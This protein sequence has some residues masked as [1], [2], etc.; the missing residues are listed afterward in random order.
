MSWVGQYPS[1]GELQDMVNEAD[2]DKSGT[3]DLRG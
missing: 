2:T 1:E 3:I